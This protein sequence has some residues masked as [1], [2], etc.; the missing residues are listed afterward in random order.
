M[1]LAGARKS[2]GASPFASGSRH[3]GTSPSGA[4]FPKKFA[5]CISE[6]ILWRT[7]IDKSDQILRIQFP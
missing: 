5:G 1:E 2:L 7:Q 3:P 6:E 4:P